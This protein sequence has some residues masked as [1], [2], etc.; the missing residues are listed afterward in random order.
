MNTI[1]EDIIKQQITEIDLN[2]WDQVIDNALYSF[3]F[4]S[5]GE[6]LQNLNALFYVFKACDIK[7]PDDSIINTFNKLT[8]RDGCDIIPLYNKIDGLDLQES[9]D[10][11]RNE[12]IYLVENNKTILNYTPDNT[13]TLYELVDQLEDILGNCQIDK[14]YNYTNIRHDI[15]D[16]PIEM[17][18]YLSMVDNE[19]SVYMKLVVTIGDDL[20]IEKYDDNLGFFVPGFGFALNKGL[21]S[22]YTSKILTYLG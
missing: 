6:T 11:L 1:I 13:T 10:V 14:P 4:T 5:G 2:R 19:D 12:L 22:A 17:T 8:Y 16:K 7:I 18:S 9:I 21:L 15:I 3:N 20:Y